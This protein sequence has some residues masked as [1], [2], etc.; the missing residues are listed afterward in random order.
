[1]LQGALSM[2]RLST[3]NTSNAAACMLD[4]HSNRM[5]QMGPK[6]TYPPIPCKAKVLFAIAV[7]VDCF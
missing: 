2:P 1:M 6:L 4:V 5:L 7:V 3:F